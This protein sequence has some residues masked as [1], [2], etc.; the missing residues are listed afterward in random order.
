MGECE[1]CQCPR[2]A[3]GPCPG[4]G[5]LPSYDVPKGCCEYCGNK[6]IDDCKRCGAPVCCPVCCKGTTDKIIAGKHQVSG[7]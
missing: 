3:H 2:N 1:Y 7:Q 6:L 4:C 5:K